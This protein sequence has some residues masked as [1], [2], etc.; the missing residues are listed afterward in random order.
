MN[1][2]VINKQKYLNV[3]Y[4]QFNKM[5]ILKFHFLK[6]ILLDV[7]INSNKLKI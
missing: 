4:F 1:V 2:H 6:Y 7:K 3:K 5:F